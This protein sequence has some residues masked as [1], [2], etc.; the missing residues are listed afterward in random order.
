M[1][2]RENFTINTVA[3]WK[4]TPVEPKKYDVI[5]ETESYSFTNSGVYRKSKFWGPL[6][7]ARLWLIK[8]FDSNNPKEQV[9]YCEFKDFKKPEMVRV[10]KK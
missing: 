8:T 2:T 5:T 6:S 1:I 3:S 4:T 7:N 9:G 10:E